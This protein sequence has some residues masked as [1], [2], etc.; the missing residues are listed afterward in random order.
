L[1]DIS[2]NNQR[3]A[4]V[5]VREYDQDNIYENLIYPNQR[6]QVPVPDPNADPSLSIDKYKIMESINTSSSGRGIINQ[7]SEGKFNGEEE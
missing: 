1:S 4:S 7:D 6:F 2:N 3:L 5:L